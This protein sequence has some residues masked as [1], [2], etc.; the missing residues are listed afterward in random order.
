MNESL[1]AFRRE[2][3]KYTVADLCRRAGWESVT[4]RVMDVL[5][6]LLEKYMLK[7]STTAKAFSELC[8]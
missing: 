4:C 5:V 7:L 3:L 8:E 1:V 6:E 2:V